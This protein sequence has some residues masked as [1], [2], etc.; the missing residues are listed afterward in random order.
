MSGKVVY[1]VTGQPVDLSEAETE[2]LAEVVDGMNEEMSR[3]KEARSLVE[4]ELARRM[5]KLHETAGNFR[6]SHFPRV[7]VSKRTDV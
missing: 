6:L 4:R 3:L 7:Y 2:T 1:S 5:T